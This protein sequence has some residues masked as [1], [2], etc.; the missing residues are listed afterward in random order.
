MEQLYRAYLP[1]SSAKWFNNLILNE[2][3]IDLWLS[4]RLIHD[5][6]NTSLQ[7]FAEFRV[8]NSSILMNR[9]EKAFE[10]RGIKLKILVDDL[11]QLS[12]VF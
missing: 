10:E 7:Y 11:N 12:Q 6:K 1:K 2:P 3:E 4:T 5:I 9:Y 8:K